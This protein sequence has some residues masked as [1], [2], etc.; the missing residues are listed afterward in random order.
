MDQDFT[1]SSILAEFHWSPSKIEQY[2]P[3][4]HLAVIGKWILHYYIDLHKFILD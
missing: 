3:M 1:F 2:V 4:G